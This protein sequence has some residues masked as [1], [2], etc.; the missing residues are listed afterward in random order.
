MAQARLCESL[1]IFCPAMAQNARVYKGQD[2]SASSSSRT[3][4]FLSVLQL[5]LDSFRTMEEQ[6]L[7]G[8]KDEARKKRDH[9]SE[10]IKKVISMT[11]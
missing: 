1:A 3:L 6:S 10:K 7:Q 8:K 11:V 9:E 5:R 4:K 2:H